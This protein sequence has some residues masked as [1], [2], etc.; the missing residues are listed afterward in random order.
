MQAFPFLRE[1]LLCGIAKPRWAWILVLLMSVPGRPAHAQAT[2][3]RPGIGAV[4]R[5]PAKPRKGHLPLRKRPPEAGHYRDDGWVT[6]DWRSACGTS[7]QRRNAYDGIFNAGDRISFTD[8][9]LK[10][11]WFTGPVP[12]ATPDSITGQKLADY[13][14]HRVWAGLDSV[15][16]F[17]GLRS[18]YGL[19]H[20]SYARFVVDEAGYC[21]ALP[22]ER[23]VL[24]EVPELP[25]ALPAAEDQCIGRV[26]ARLPRVQLSASVRG[27][28]VRFRVALY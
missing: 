23:L 24:S 1:P 22:T 12:L 2:K 16:E 19:S 11:S 7:E 8:A 18:I 14:H 27:V 4:R 6:S 13:V 5:S 9:L 15:P 26:L 3:A 28:A 17:R 10:E 25:E 20:Q 21:H